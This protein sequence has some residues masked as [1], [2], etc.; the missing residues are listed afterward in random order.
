MMKYDEI[1]VKMR[2]RAP[3]SH[4]SVSNAAR[5]KTRLNRL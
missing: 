5:L 1:Q 2:F 4:I 3:G